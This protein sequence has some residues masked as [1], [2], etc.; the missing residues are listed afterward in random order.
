M[1]ESIVN[2]VVEHKETQLP[3]P[4]ARRGIDEA[5]WRTAMNSLFPG[6]KAESV[7]MVFDYCRA[8]KLDPLKKP[9]HIVPMK[10]GNDWR[11]VVMP[12]IY[13]YRVTANRTGEYLGHSKPV[14]GPTIEHLGVHA[15]EYCELTVYRWNPKAQ[16][17]CEFP[18][19]VK[20]TECVAT[21]W[22]KEARGPKVNA[23]WTKAPQQ[24]LTKC[25]EAAGLREAFPDELGGEH[26]AEEMEGQSFSQTEAT[27]I[28]PTERVDP[29]GDVSGVDWE[30][31]DRHVMAIADILNGEEE[32]IH[33]GIYEYVNEH[34]MKHPELFI[35]VNDKLAKDGIITKAKFRKL[36]EEKPV[37]TDLDRIP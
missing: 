17:K 27:V 13:E 11:D 29:R 22:D 36:Y 7:L 25:T 18:V 2:A 14:Y 4:V 1:E 15:P 30:V 9:C 10:V 24:M 12:G 28:T 34:L 31:R 3:A 20:F 16:Q 23:R 5:A 26:T 35:T 32:Q 37:P 21:A 19:Q 6:A 33:Q 8:R